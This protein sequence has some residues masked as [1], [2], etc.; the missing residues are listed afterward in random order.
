MKRGRGEG[1]EGGLESPERERGRLGDR[2]TDA[3]TDG[4]W[5]RF[6]GDNEPG[7]LYSRAAEPSEMSDEGKRRGLIRV[8]AEERTGPRCNQSGCVIGAPREWG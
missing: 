5:T 2:W 8:A 1:T 3:A 4:G 7:L 6:K